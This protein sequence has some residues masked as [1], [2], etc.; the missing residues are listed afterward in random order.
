MTQTMRQQD[1]EQFQG[2][3]S[4]K[5]SLGMTTQTNLEVLVMHPVVEELDEKQDEQDGAR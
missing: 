1:D 3:P 4:S 2:M 5:Y